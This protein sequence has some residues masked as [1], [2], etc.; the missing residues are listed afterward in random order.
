MAAY[1][2]KNIVI[3]QNNLDG[4]QMYAWPIDTDIY[5]YSYLDILNI[6]VRR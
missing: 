5:K 4:M 3:N 6:L 2:Q 1:S